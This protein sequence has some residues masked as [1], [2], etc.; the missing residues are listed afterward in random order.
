MPKTAARVASSSR[1]VRETLADAYFEALR[2]LAPRS[3]ERLINSS[4]E[5]LEAHREFLAERI[6]RLEKA[7]ARVGGRGARAAARKVRVRRRRTTSA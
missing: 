3:T 7:K 1:R 6:A 2:E 5:M 4:I